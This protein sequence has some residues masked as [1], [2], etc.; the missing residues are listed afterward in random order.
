MAIAQL[1]GIQEIKRTVFLVRQ[2]TQKE[3]VKTK[4]F[5]NNNPPQCMPL[6]VT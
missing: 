2:T 5:P 1:L 6:Q 3:N 4:L